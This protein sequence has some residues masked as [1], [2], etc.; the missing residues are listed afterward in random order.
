MSNK[1]MNG[2]PFGT[3]GLAVFTSVFLAL[4]PST[5][6]DWAIMNG[7]TVSGQPFGSSAGLGAGNLHMK[8]TPVGDTY[9]QGWSGGWDYV[10]TNYTPNDSS[11]G[12]GI[13]G[14]NWGF[15][16]SPPAPPGQISWTITGSG[17]GWYAT[18]SGTFVAHDPGYEDVIWADFHS[19]VPNI[20][21]ADF[22]QGGTQC[23]SKDAPPMA[24]FSVHALLVSLNIIDRPLRYT[25]PVGP[26]VDFIV[27]YNQKDT[28]QP[29]T[30]GYSNLGPKWTFN[31][32]SYVTDDPNSQAPQTSV[33]V[34]G[35]GEEAYFFDYGPN[36]IRLTRRA[37]RL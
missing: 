11:A 23:P 34:P 14:E 3:A 2:L 30:F 20:T 31:W 5:F 19:G 22:K 24:Q 8:V 35:G 13:E 21:P 37:T 28:Q 26:A 4:P 25:P 17:P 29:A 12:W 33:Y 9:T 6:A 16:N 1:T 27:T 10:R 36:L 15:W 18:G 32:L 7:R